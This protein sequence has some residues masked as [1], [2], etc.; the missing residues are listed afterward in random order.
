MMRRLSWIVLSVYLPSF[1][2]LAVEVETKSF[3]EMAKKV[4]EMGEKHGKDNVLVVYDID[5][6]LMAMNQD[7]GSDQWF[8]WQE[9]L[10][11][12]DSKRVS[13]NFAGLLS[14]QGTLFALSGMKTPEP[15]T[16]KI[17]KD[18]QTKGF[19][20]I[21][22]TSRGPE[23]RNLTARELKRN[24]LDFY[25][26]AIG[27]EGGYPSSFNPFKGIESSFTDE[28]KKI[29]KIDSARAISFQDGVMMT[30][31]QHK[32]AMLKAIL[33]KTDFSPKAVVFIDDHKK[34][35]ERVE[36]TFKDSGI[37]TWSFRY[38]AWDANVEKFKKSDKRK[39]TQDWKKVKAVIEQVFAK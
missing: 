5:N 15:Y 26:S 37:E 36:A 24:D 31:G 10:K 7:L 12:K 1:Q 9:E 4:I 30:S 21:V 19:K 38:G 18:L 8:I 16:A 35:T 6:T 20:S 33:K 23:F 2:L 11:E 13:D 34:H 22:L 29:Y 14:A 28:E 32:G 39:V 3:D 25:S 17:V 27:P